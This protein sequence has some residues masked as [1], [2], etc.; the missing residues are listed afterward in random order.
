MR[1]IR[2]IIICIF[3]IHCKCYSQE[4]LSNFSIKD[5]TSN[6]NPINK[7]DLQFKKIFRNDVKKRIRNDLMFGLEIYSKAINDSALILQAY[8]LDINVYH[9][10]ELGSFK[11][12]FSLLMEL[13]KKDRNKYDLGFVTKYLGISQQVLAI[14]LAIIS[15][16]K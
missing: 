5:S 16:A 1:C 4:N 6:V 3:I 13:E 15:V 10:E 2:L 11:E 14:I 8:S 9:K 7:N 12:S